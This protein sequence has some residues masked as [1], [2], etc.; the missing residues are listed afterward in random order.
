MGLKSKLDLRLKFNLDLGV[1]FGEMPEIGGGREWAGTGGN[2]LER[3]GWSGMGVTWRARH[4]DFVITMLVES[5][6]SAV[7]AHAAFAV[8][9][10]PLDGTAV[11]K[12]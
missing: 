7:P 1:K 5:T 2:G 4:G 10:P 6:C 11:L 8:Q 9:Y 12:T 3:R